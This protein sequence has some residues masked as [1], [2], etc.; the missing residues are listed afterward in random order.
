MSADEAFCCGTAA[1]IS[2]IG[3]ITHGDSEKIYQ[4]RAVGTVTRELYDCLVG[5]HTEAE[6][7]T[8]GW[9]HRVDLEMNLD[10]P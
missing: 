2:P 5:I 8:F 1:V 10:R 6:D 7:D 4:D 9:M 3:S